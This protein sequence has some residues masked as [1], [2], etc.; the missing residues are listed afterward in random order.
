MFFKDYKFWIWLILWLFI[1]GCFVYF[2]G[3]GIGG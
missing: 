1:L 2:V 3:L